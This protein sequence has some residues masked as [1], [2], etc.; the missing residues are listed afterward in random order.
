MTMHF[1][2]TSSRALR[3]HRDSLGIQSVK[4]HQGSVREARRSQKA[5]VRLAKTDCKHSEASTV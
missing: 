2:A 3:L 4:Y 5:F 1:T